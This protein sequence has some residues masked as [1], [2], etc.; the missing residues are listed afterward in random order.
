MQLLEDVIQTEQN[1]KIENNNVDNPKILKRVQGPLADFTKETRNGRRYTKELWEKVLSSDLV[2]EL[3]ETKSLLGEA[4]HPSDNEDRLEVE[5]KQVS[6]HISEAWIDEEDGLVYGTIDILDTPNGRIINNLVEYGTRI[7]AS[8]RGAGN[9]IEK[10]GEKI[11]EADSYFFVTWDLVALPSNKP[12]RMSPVSESKNEGKVEVQ[13]LDNRQDK[14]LGS[15]K[16]QVEKAIKEGDKRELK[17][18]RNLLEATENDKFDPLLEKLSK[19]IESGCT[20][21]KTEENIPMNLTENNKDTKES[22]KVTRLKEDLKEAYDKIAELKA[23]R[24]GENIVE[25]VNKTIDIE[26]ENFDKK[27]DALEE[28]VLDELNSLK[29]LLSSLPGDG[30]L[31]E[32]VVTSLPDKDGKDE[33][34]QEIKDIKEDMEKSKDYEVF[35]QR[36]VDLLGFEEKVEFDE[37]CNTIADVLDEAYELQD[38]VE[39]LRERVDELEDSLKYK[40]ETLES[41]Q[42]IVE[43]YTQLLCKRKGVDY[44][45]VREQLPESLTNSDLDRIHSVVEREK[46]RQKRLS[47]FSRNLEESGDNVREVKGKDESRKSEEDETKQRMGRVVD[48]VRNS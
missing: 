21:C 4:D 28:N 1:F 45:S 15:M 23:E 47:N 19:S 35:Y 31:K 41:Y 12:A 48:R 33:I 42:D 13:N 3:L 11:V 2:K 32:Q 30:E 6:H 16:K 40:E 24:D 9:V 26:S 8:S 14:V 25:K 20:G 37:I 29:S 46:K 39:E 7:G 10:D 44:S 5:L 18:M 27:L 38:E 22:N 34:L 43:D 36:I 17:R